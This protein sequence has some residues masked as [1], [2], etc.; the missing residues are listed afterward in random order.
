L[1]KVGGTIK[2]MIPLQDFTD[3]LRRADEPPWELAAPLLA[4]WYDGKGD[5]DR[6]HETVQDDESRDAAWVHAYL[7]RKEGDSGNAR[8]WYRRAGREASDLP[9]EREWDEIVSQLLSR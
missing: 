6:A 4:L 9:L 3:S 8:Y 1:L 2:R 5:W 7:H